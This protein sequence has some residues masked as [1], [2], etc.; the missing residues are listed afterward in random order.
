MHSEQ[1][2]KYE[3]I[4]SRFRAGDENQDNGNGEDI[5]P[6]GEVETEDQ[7]KSKIKEALYFD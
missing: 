1:A 6:E 2:Q 4:N 5:G 3:D 7:P